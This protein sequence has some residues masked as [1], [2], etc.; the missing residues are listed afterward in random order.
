[1]R[2]REEKIIKDLTKGD[3]MT[4]FIK[5]IE[6][7]NSPE[8]FKKLADLYLTNPDEAWKE[9][10]LALAKQIIKDKNTLFKR[11]SDL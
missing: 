11:L 2:E 6:K 9:Y 3:E 5:K 7:L 10:R 8:L 4:E 1:M